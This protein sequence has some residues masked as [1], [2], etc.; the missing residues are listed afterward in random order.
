MN[1]FLF[2]ITSFT[3][4]CKNSLMFFDF[5]PIKEDLNFHEYSTQ[6]GSFTVI[7]RLTRHI[8]RVFLCAFLVVLFFN[9]SSALHGASLISNIFRGTLFLCYSSLLLVFFLFLSIISPLLQSNICLFLF[10]RYIIPIASIIVFISIIK[11]YI[12]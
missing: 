12:W 11:L 4:L 10:K 5:V 8:D 6:I 1:I 2:C 7:K 3:L 9:Y